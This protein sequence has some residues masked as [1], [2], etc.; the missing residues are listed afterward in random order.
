MPKIFRRLFVLLLFSILVVGCSSNEIPT[1]NL[2]EKSGEESSL[3]SSQ[4]VKTG[5]PAPTSTATSKPTATPT[6]TTTPTSTLPPSPT[7]LK[8]GLP[9]LERITVENADRVELLTTLRIP[10]YMVVNPWQGQC[11]VAFSL[12]GSLL[13]A[14]C[15]QNALPVWD[16]PSLE[17]RHRLFSMPDHA[18]S[19]DFSPDGRMVACGK[20]DDWTIPAW[21]AQ[22][23]EYLY[24]IGKH[25]APVW[26]VDFS[27]DGKFLAS[28]SVSEGDFERRRGK[29][30]ILWKVSPPEKLW[31][32]E[33]WSTCL[34][35]SFHPSGKTIA[36]SAIHGKV[37]I[38]DAKT[39]ELIV[40]LEDATRHLG[41]IVYSPS[42]DYLSATSDD[43]NI[44]IW[45]V[46]GYNLVAKLEGHQSYVNGSAFSEDDTYLVSG[47]ADKTVAIWSLEDFQMLTSLVGHTDTILRIDLNRENT[48]IA[49][50]SWDGTVRLW[51]IIAE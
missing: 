15:E 32:H 27:P 28:C 48:L 4:E 37:E 45:D 6:E 21:N 35:I 29:M 13:V 44:F 49:S 10:N 33:M 30:A 51:G 17:L 43:F 47:S 12:D 7:P 19:C 39:G 25:S 26:D 36:A 23:G 18:I 20:Y 41:D 11:G 22:T 3:R 14:T 24:D 8:D 2:S 40:M 46:P 50:V 31:S 9:N 34:S 1:S 42:G 38:L 16:L 5:M